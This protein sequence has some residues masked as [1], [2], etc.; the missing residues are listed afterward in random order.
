MIS[1][2]A[3]VMNSD[4]RKTVWCWSTDRDIM[5]LRPMIQHY[6][7]YGDWYTLDLI[8]W[9]I[10]G[11]SSD[12]MSHTCI[13][14]MCPIRASFVNPSLTSASSAAQN[15]ITVWLS[16]MSDDI[17]NANLGYF[18]DVVKFWKWMSTALYIMH[19]TDTTNNIKNQIQCWLAVYSSWF[20]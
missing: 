15:H 10:V 4:A 7:I 3:R 11:T 1:T 12:A 14:M 2:S 6:K 18:S 9:Y 17:F 5:L 13:P 16:L 8:F 20:H 19:D